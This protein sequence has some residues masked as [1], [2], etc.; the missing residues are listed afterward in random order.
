MWHI[1][2][3]AA[4]DGRNCDIYGSRHAECCDDARMGSFKNKAQIYALMGGLLFGA[5]LLISGMANPAKVIGFL[6]IFGAFDAGLAF[7][8]I[9]TI[10]VAIV[11]FTLAKRHMATHDDGKFDL[12][13]AT[14]IDRS[15]ITGA[16]LFGIG[17]GLVGICPAPALSLMGLGRFEALYFFMPMLVAMFGFDWVRRHGSKA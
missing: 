13:T 17:W 16:L 12:P 15:L 4:L 3:F 11:P 1:R 8:M 7:V 10:S 9:G 5:G 14:S 6:D 2:T